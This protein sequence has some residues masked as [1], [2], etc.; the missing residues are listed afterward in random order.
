VKY[1]SVMQL[2]QESIT[3]MHPNRKTKRSA[4]GQA[5]TVKKKF[6]TELAGTETNQVYFFFLGKNERSLVLCVH[7][8]SPRK[9]ESGPLTVQELIQSTDGTSPVL[10]LLP[11]VYMSV[12][13]FFE[14]NVC[15]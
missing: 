14:K 10:F 6:H 7:K 8:C 1:D 3:E 12:F 13:F 4:Y 9:S 5:P 11:D 15:M 2:G